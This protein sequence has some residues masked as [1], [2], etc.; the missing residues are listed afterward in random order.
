[1]SLAGFGGEGVRYYL[2]AD[3]AIRRVVS[4]REK[5]AESSRRDAVMTTPGTVMIWTHPTPLP[6]D[7]AAN[8]QRYDQGCR[9]KRPHC[10]SSGAG[11]VPIGRR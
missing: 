3:R 9:H 2:R 1:M 4:V 10:R 8:A 6:A 7:L 5:L 11:V